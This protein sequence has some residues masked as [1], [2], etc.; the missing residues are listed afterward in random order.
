MQLAAHLLWALLFRLSTRHHIHYLSAGSLLVRP[1]WLNK[2]L[3]LW[4]HEHRIT[5]HILLPCSLTLGL[6]LPQTIPLRLAI[7]LVV[8]VYHLVESSAT[9]RHGEYP[10]L[11][12]VWAVCLPSE[13]A[14]GVSL[15]VVTHFV[16]SAGA[17]KVRVGGLCSWA[18]PSTMAT[19]LQIFGKSTSAA[20]LSRVLNQMLSSRPWATTLTGV[21]T[22]AL[23]LAIV[24]ALLFAP[25]A[26]RWLGSVLMVLLHTGILVVMSR[27]VGAAFLTTLPAYI[28]GFGCDAQVGQVRVPRLPSECKIFCAAFHTVKPCR[29]S[30]VG[31]QPWLVATAIALLPTCTVSVCGLSIPEAWPFSPFALF[32]CDVTRNNCTRPLYHRARFTHLVHAR[33]VDANNTHSTYHP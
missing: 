25:P 6:I 2:R 21:G 33:D 20:P 4:L 3:L 22:L 7:A 9:S 31:S 29:F 28:I 30:Q 32:M 24:P 10:L 26:L 1:P 11:Y 14:S 8:S 17:A 12:C 16:L 27:S 13:Y 18:A 5:V 23:E 19:Y 15:G